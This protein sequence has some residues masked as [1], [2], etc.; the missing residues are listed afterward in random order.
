MDRQKKETNVRGIKIPPPNPPNAT[1]FSLSPSCKETIVWWLC[2]IQHSTS[3]RIKEQDEEV[4]IFQFFFFPD[5]QEGK[6]G[7]RQTVGWRGGRGMIRLIS[8]S[9]EVGNVGGLWW[10]LFPRSGGICS[11]GTNRSVHTIGC[12]KHKWEEAWRKWLAVHFV[13]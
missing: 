3:Y 5:K 7:N 10:L 12:D 2:E 11:A 8:A 13:V 4:A 9:K 1:F 6:R